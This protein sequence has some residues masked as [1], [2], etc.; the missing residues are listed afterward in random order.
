MKTALAYLLVS[1]A[2]VSIDCFVIGR[3]ESVLALV[4]VMPQSVSVA[5]PNQNGPIAP[6]SQPVAAYDKNAVEQ[7]LL[8]SF[9]QSLQQNPPT[10][11]SNIGA[12]PKLTTAGRSL[13]QALQESQR[14]K[15]VGPT[16]HGI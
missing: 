4:A 10:F 7:D 16:T 8:A 13:D 6:S 1:Q 3:R 12:S 9:G 2:S 5:A 14:A 15:L 11:S